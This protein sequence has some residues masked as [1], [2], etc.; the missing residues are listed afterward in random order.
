VLEH[1][2]SPLDVRMRSCVFGP[3]LEPEP[4]PDDPIYI[5]GGGKLFALA[6]GTFHLLDPPPP[7]PP[8]AVWV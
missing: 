1:T 6:T 5:P 4:E 2:S 8:A 3:R 7:T